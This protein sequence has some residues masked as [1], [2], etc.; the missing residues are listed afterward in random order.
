MVFISKGGVKIPTCSEMNPFRTTTVMV[1]ITFLCTMWCSFYWKWRNLWTRCFSFPLPFWHRKVQFVLWMVKYASG[2]F[3]STLIAW[4]MR[5]SFECVERNGKSKHFPS[6]SAWFGDIEFVW[7][8]DVGRFFTTCRWF[9]LNLW[10]KGICLHGF[11][12]SHEE[13]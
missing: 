2:D 13:H 1:S 12:Q 8:V 5:C 3:T 6:P 4:R 7:Q 10:K 9:N 11:W